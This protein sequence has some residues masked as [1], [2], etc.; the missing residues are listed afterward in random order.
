MQLV[1]ARGVVVTADD[2]NVTFAVAS[3]PVRIVGVG[4]GDNLNRQH[5]QGARCQT[6]RGLGRVV[7]Q[8]TVDCTSAARGLAGQIDLDPTIAFA[9]ACPTAVAVV[10]ARVPGLPSVQVASRAFKWI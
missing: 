2:R 10:T 5:V 8:A 4:S 1:D 9:E 3:G 6:F 7:V